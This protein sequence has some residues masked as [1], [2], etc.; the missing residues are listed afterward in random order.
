MTQFAERTRDSVVA[1]VE[2]GE[3]RLRSVVERE[4]QALAAAEEEEA[5]P[6]PPRRPGGARAEGVPVNAPLPPTRPFALGRAPTKSSHHTKLAQ[7]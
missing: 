4:P 1:A 2:Q 6:T 7:R 3:D 5:S